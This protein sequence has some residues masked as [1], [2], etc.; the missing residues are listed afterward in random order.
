MAPLRP[1]QFMAA[2]RGAPDGR[3]VAE[4]ARWAESVGFTHIAAHDHLANRHAV[5]PLLAAIAASTERVGL[6]PLV[7][8]NDLRHPAVLAQELASID[9]LSG[10]RLVVGLGAGWNEPEYDA[11]WLPFDKAGTRIDRMLESIAIMKGL[12]GQGRFSYQGRFYTITDMDGGPKPIQKPHPP[13]LIGGTRERVLRL[14]AQH[15]DIVGIDLRS[16]GEAVLDAFEARMEARIGW[17]RDAAGASFVQKDLNVLRSIGELVVTDNALKVAGDVARELAGDTGQEISA[18][19]VLE[20]PFAFIGSVPELVDKF[21]RLRQRWGI[22]SFL[23][24]W[25]G[26]S[27]LR[28]FA[29]VVEQLSGT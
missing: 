14:A 25:F 17:I 20:S 11:I 28:D 13:F 1:F 27:G 16:E 5:T 24:G 6:V 4:Q 10:G 7:Y 3:T 18:H 12:F 19:D 22:N 29:P 2:S 21:T 15:G 23:V 9:V 26:E 8:N